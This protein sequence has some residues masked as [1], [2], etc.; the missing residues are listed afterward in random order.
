MS[1]VPS[2]PV[3]T[4]K[5]MYP[6]NDAWRAEVKAR[7]AE[8]RMSAAEIARVARISGATLSGLLNGRYGHSHAVPSI[9][10]MLGLPPPTMAD[11]TAD[12]DSAALQAL[13][14]V[15]QLSPEDLKAWIDLGRRMARTDKKP[16]R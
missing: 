7:M 10:R 12:E 4:S 15:E 8:R 1:E 13:A 11:G 14:L 16:D 9:N 6:V 3:P 5:R 2:V